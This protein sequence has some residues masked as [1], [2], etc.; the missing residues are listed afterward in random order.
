MVR[1]KNRLLHKRIRE[2]FMIQ[3]L[4][5]Q[6]KIDEDKGYVPD[7]IQDRVNSESNYEWAKGFP[8]IRSEDIKRGGAPRSNKSTQ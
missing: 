3:P 8:I 7:Q 6:F 1:R 5:T 2:T 4:K